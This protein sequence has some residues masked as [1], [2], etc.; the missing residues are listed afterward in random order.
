MAARVLETSAFGTAI[1]ERYGLTVMSLPD[2]VLQYSTPIVLRGAIAQWPA[3]QAAHQ[4]DAAI[5]DYLLQF[6][7]GMPVTLLRAPACCNGRLFYN[8]SF[9]GFN[10][11]REAS[12]LDQVLGSLLADASGD[13]R[14]VGSTTLEH[15]LP[16]FAADNVM[17]A[18][19]ARQSLV[20]I[21][22]GNRS[23]ISAH[24]DLPSNLACVVA[25]RRRFTL[26]PPDQIENLY[27]GPF[28][29]TPAG[30]PVSL[31]DFAAI[32]FER[33]PRFRTAMAHAVTAELGAGDALLIPSLWWHHI[34]ALSDLNVLVN[35]WWGAAG[36][37]YESPINALLHAVL[38]LGPLDAEQK[39]AL[40]SLFEHY[41]F[42]EDP[43]RFHHIPAAARGL[44][45]SDDENSSRR[46]RAYLYNA[47][48]R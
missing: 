28:E 11:Q 23:V 4:S 25:G 42:G 48:K 10:F 33:F 3:V 44:L 18:L 22:L 9:T 36:S 26:F 17:P 27:V 8:D 40:K 13:T 47:L 38:A 35:Y 29:L 34:A 1:P 16:G 15:C 37:Q 2:D 24:F 21:W 41:V 30:Q 12:T 31:V 5:S 32:D 7:R 45:N 19:A 46:L 6:Y 39:R 43:T 14:Y 20:S